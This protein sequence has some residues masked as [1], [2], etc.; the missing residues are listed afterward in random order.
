MRKFMIGVLTG[1]LLAAFGGLNAFA[2]SGSGTESSP[3]L[4]CTREDYCSFAEIVNAGETALYARLE[5]DLDFTDTSYP[6]VGTAAH[7]FEGVFDGNGHA[8]CGIAITSADACFTAS[9]VTAVGAFGYIR[10]AAIRD[11]FVEDMT[12][13][14]TDTNGN[15]PRAGLLCGVCAYTKNNAA[16]GI[17]RCATS[18]SITISS[19]A[20]AYA[21]GLFGSLTASAEKA[22]I[23][24]CD[25]ASDVT[26]AVE[27][28]YSLY[29]GG[30]IGKLEVAQYLSEFN[31]ARCVVS[32]DA[33]FTGSATTVTVG[34]LCGFARMDNEWRSSASLSAVQGGFENCLVT[35]YRADG[36]G[37][38][39]YSA[40][41]VGYVNTALN[42]TMCCTET[43]SV[44]R[45]ST[46]YGISG[47][48]TAKTSFA[49][50]AWLDSLGFDMVSVWQVSDGVPTLCRCYEDPPVSVPT[51]CAFRTRNVD[52][53]LTDGMRFMA[54]ISDEQFNRTAEYGFIVTRNV[55]LER[56]GV[57]KD[58]FTKNTMP[59]NR[60]VT[61]VSY[62]K[63]Q[64]IDRA[65]G[66]DD[67]GNVRF[68]GFV[69]GDSPVFPDDEMVVRPY[70]VFTTQ[71]SENVFYGDVMSATLNQ[72]KNR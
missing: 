9:K 54:Y 29:G 28:R 13:D 11:L 10:D 48:K 52:G 46:A 44:T 53:S 34:G 36:D 31:A 2:L 59:E 30:L 3:Y 58:A 50:T 43:D 6:I 42:R 41:L 40:D 66:I 61:G 7:P 67:A 5:N 14:I 56:E 47:S 33:S 37:N 68:A 20:S 57:E 1:T 8:L 4:I 62:S 25:C 17:E 35:A 71:N 19:A 15:T 70:I 69:Y 16:P 12:I 65:A 51:E 64:N 72:L 49:D 63:A 39:F 21:A 45:T 26:L 22:R 38:N 18:G 32:A 24:I 23:G 60:Y 27:G 55:L